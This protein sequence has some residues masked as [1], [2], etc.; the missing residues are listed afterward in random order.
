M[1]SWQL[2]RRTFLRGAGVGLALPMLDAMAGTTKAAESKAPRRLA[3]VFFPNGVSLPEPKHRDH[4]EWHWFPH[5]EGKDFKFTKTLESLEPLRDRISVLG[6]LSH[7]SG[8]KLPGHSV[9]DVF[10]TG[11]KVGTSTYTNSISVDQVYATKVGEHTRLPSLALSTTGGVGQSGRTNTMS[12]TREGQPIPAEDN[13]RRAFNRM[14]GNTAAREIEVHRSVAQ[15]QKSMLDLVLEDAN[16]LNRNLGRDDQK[17]LEEY[18]NS[19]RELERR[20]IRSEQWLNVPSA[21]VDSTLLKL[22]STREAPVDYIR[23]MY[24]LMFHAFQTD[25]TRVATYLI[26]TEGGGQLSDVFPRALGLSTIHTLSHSTNKTEDGFKRWALW[27]Q[28]LAQQFAYFLMKL[29]NTREGDSN[30]LDRTTVLYGC[31]T[32]PKPSVISG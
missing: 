23:A 31:S 10:L 8:R 5:G 1:K 6:G 3:C 7:P 21:K 28:F 32:S 24:D 2:N 20:V 22:E 15:R 19:V 4:Q 9:S 30:L 12:F 18:L 26:G 25:T 27:D 17:K 13:L 14:F 29:K 11:S 16:N